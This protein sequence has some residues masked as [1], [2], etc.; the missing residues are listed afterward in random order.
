MKLFNTLLAVSFLCLTS[1][2]QA[3]T[4]LHSSALLL[5]GALLFAIGTRQNNGWRKW[6]LCTFLIT[7]STAAI[8]SFLAIGADVIILFSFAAAG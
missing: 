2:A 8:V 6:V 7:F 5:G 1:G 4:L 3:A